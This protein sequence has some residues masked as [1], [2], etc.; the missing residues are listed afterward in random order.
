MVHPGKI[1]ELET[2]ILPE[3]NEAS[4]FPTKKGIR[5][6]SRMRLHQVMKNHL[7]VE[8][9]PVSRKHV[10]VTTRSEVPR[11]SHCFKKKKERFLFLQ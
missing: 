10:R 6:K 3:T 8:K 5:A 2:H 1:L 11:L 4:Y 9:G 7:S